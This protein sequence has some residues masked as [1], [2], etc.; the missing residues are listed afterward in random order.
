MTEPAENY[1]SQA[2]AARMR[3]QAFW[4]WGAFSVLVL[5]WVLL[6][7]LVPVAASSGYETLSK[8]VYT[9]FSYICHQMPERSMHL[10]GHQLGVCSRCFGVYFGLFLGFAV[11]PLW[12]RVDDIEPLPRFWLFLSMV[13]IGI[14]W[15]LGMFEIWENNHL[16]RFVT[17]LILGFAC[18][19]YIIPAIVEIFR[20]LLTKQRTA[21]G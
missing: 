11:Y 8:P 3:R 12:R 19:T 2:M 17:G 15:T 14:D 10:V 13:P 1:V 9:F 21:Q 6:I 7:V 16:S 20:Y 4:V 18:A 5:A